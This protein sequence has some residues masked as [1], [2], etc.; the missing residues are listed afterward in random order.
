MSGLP[1]GMQIE[2]VIMLAFML[3]ASFDARGVGPHVQEL[4]R[5]ACMYTLR[6]T[7]GG[8]RCLWDKM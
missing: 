2:A 6:G 5:H 8:T 7:A 4:S 1:A 3:G